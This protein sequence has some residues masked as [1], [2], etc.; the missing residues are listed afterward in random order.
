MPDLRWK[1]PCRRAG[2]GE[3]DAFYRGLAKAHRECTK[4]RGRLALVAQ[5]RMPHPQP[6]RAATESGPQGHHE[7]ENPDPDT[8]PSYTGP[9]PG[10]D[11]C[12][13]ERET[14]WLESVL[15]RS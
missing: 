15:R 5:L 4:E 6:E 3:S 9:L 8:E 11:D 14:A 2:N 12:K 10:P 1:S 13:S 7:V